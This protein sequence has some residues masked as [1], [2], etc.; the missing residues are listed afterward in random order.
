MTALPRGA[1]A[2]L[3]AGAFAALALGVSPL[4]GAESLEWSQVMAG[5]GPESEIFWTLRL[6]RV[7]LAALAGAVLAVAGVVYQA[8]FRN[9]LATPF[10]LGIASGASLGAVL[11]IHLGLVVVIFGVSTLPLFAF[12]GACIVV[13]SVFSLARA[14]GRTMDPATMLLGGVTV[15]FLCTAVIL[16]IQ[17]LSDAGDTNRM[18]RWMMG[19]L[20]V[21]GWTPVVRSAPFAVVAGAW[22][23]MRTRVLDQ[24]LTGDALAASRGIAVRRERLLLLLAA[25][26]AAGALIAFT[27]PIGFVGLIVP[28]AMR[29]LGGPTHG[30]LVVSSALAGAGFLALADTLARTVAAPTEI[31]V[32][33][34]TALL[35]APFFLGLLLRRHR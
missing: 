29:R 7:A 19:G 18:I 4:V 17:F 9:D 13:F 6:P 8:V 31:P 5:S 23:L 3:G 22:I 35:G 34:L 21:V 26:M 15:S 33:I 27:G 32:G 16:M 12:T 2:T 24:L 1:L 14:G 30:W 20:D 10:T 25:S 11:A 28:H